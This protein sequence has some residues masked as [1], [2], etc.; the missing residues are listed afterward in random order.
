[1]PEAAWFVVLGL[2]A[3]ALS[4][5]IGI[6]GGVFIIPALIF[7]FKFTQHRA[8]GTTLAMLIPPIGLLA[9]LPY[10]RAGHVDVRAA[11]WICLG[12]VFGGWLGGHYAN[13]V[14]A[15]TLQRTFGAALLVIGL[16]MLWA[17]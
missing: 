10:Y 12:F 2:A 5:L 13:Q 7:L 14:P 3:G 9:V 16:R 11:A 4:G 8:E 1:M 6:G 17:K 15:L